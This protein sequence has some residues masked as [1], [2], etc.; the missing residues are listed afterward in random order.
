M[1]D[2][3]STPPRL[4]PPRRVLLGP[5]PSDPAPSILAALGMPT[6]G[7]LDPAFL[8]IMDEIGAMLRAAFGTPAPLTLPVSG[9]GSAGMETCV[10]NLVEAGDPVLVGVNGVFG[11]RLA[12][13]ARRAGAEVLEVQGTWGRALDPDQLLDAARGRSFKLLCGVHAETS[14][15][16]RS[17]IAAL[18]QVA[19]ELGALLLVDCVTSLGGEAGRARAL[20]CRRRVF[21]H[22]EV[23]LLSARP[24]TRVV[25]RARGGGA[26]RTQDAG[27]KLVLGSLARSELLGIRPGLPP[28]GAHQ[29]AVRPARGLAPLPRGRSCSAYYPA[30]AKRPRALGRDR[31]PRTRARRPARGA[32]D[33]AHRRT[34][35]Q[36][37][38]RGPSAA[39]S[40]AGVR[41]R[42]RRRARPFQRQRLA[43]RSDGRGLQPTQ[44]RASVWRDCARLS[45]NRVGAEATRSRPARRTTRPARPHQP[46]DRAHVAGAAGGSRCCGSRRVHPLVHPWHSCED[47]RH[48]RALRHGGGTAQRSLRVLRAPRVRPRRRVSRSMEEVAREREQGVPIA[49]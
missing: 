12:E 43:H 4:E 13:V 14:T 23:S 45:N 27:S 21:G 37:Y 31:G 29:H 49:N 41:D 1:K 39:P 3:L 5:G 47:P 10:V 38:R 26:R 34:R 48:D 35:A 42:D 24:C 36:R 25:L 9:T 7:H 20:G 33:A 28:H 17:D 32:S 19:D 46:R 16:A 44:R 30:R 2:N 8:A 18:R 11:T 40:A 22:S 6:L 15:G